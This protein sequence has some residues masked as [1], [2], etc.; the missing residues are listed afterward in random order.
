MSRK[1][2]KA[3]V[4]WFRK[5][6]RPLPW[7][8]TE[9]PYK[10]W[11][12]EIML[13]QT[14][15]QTVIPYYQRFLKKFPKV[16][17][18]A[19]AKEESVLK[20]WEGLGY[21]SRARNL[22]RAAKM[23]CQEFG[24]KLPDN[25]ESIRKLPGIGEYTSGAILAIA[26]KKAQPA[27][28][29]NLIRVYSRFYGVEESV[30]E[31]STLKRLWQIAKEHTPS[32][33]DEIRDFTEGMMDLGATICRPK[34]ADCGNCP[35]SWCCF[36]FSKN[37]VAQLPIKSKTQKRQK[38][39]QHIYWNQR[40]KKIAFLKKGSDPQFPEFHR[41]PFREV[42]GKADPKDLLFKEKYAITIRDFQV[43]VRS[44][45]VPKSLE[46]KIHWISES[47]IKKVLLPAID[48]KIVRRL[49]AS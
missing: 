39:C 48:R 42:K 47:Q 36:A 27:L 49:L 34:N 43:Y 41:L 8:E 21:Y 9:D 18:L 20:L 35:L 19:K 40:R 5:S 25:P 4:S 22:H 15:V 29:G 24:S 31:P 7:R 3:L 6:A 37:R 17:S 12:S 28:D 10:I 32:K 23:I 11:I 30:N 46:A 2:Q 33:K 14:T 13:Q 26:Y 1:F 38:V 16:E 44:A 45:K